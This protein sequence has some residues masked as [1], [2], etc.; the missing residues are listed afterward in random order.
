MRHIVRPGWAARQ[1][2]VTRS[3]GAISVD[4]TVGR[5]FVWVIPQQQLTNSGPRSI[6]LQHLTGRPRVAPVA[7]TRNHRPSSVAMDGVM[8]ERNDQGV[9]QQ[10]EADGGADLAEYLQTAEHESAHGDGE[11]QTGGGHHRP[12]AGHC[13]DDAGLEFRRGFPL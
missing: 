13:S 12:G 3:W 5:G 4:V 10:T 8:N 7:A 11:D 6:G 1:R 2:S 9:E